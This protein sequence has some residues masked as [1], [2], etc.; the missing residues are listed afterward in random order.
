MTRA[1]TRR[2][3]KTVRVY[4]FITASPSAIRMTRPFTSERWIRADRRRP[5]P[6]ADGRVLEVEGRD[7]G[8]REARHGSSIAAKLS[9]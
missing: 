5:T 9:T 6:R 8:G 1:V 2:P 3:A 4:M 7:D